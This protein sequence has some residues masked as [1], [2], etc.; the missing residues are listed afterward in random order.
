MEMDTQFFTWDEYLG[1][2][3]TGG[4]VLE[5]K[6]NIASEAKRRWKKN[7]NNKKNEKYAKSTCAKQ[8][9]FEEVCQSGVS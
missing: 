6:R 9:S 4:D 5:D 7:Y 1:G 8:E 3:I 2:I